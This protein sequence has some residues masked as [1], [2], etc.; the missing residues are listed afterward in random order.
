MNFNPK[1]DLGLS[2]VIWLSIIALLV[3]GLSPFFQE[4]AGIIGGALIFLFCTAIAGLIAWLWLATYYIFNENS[5]FIRGG[6][7]TKSV[8]FD[9]ISKVKLIRSWLA[10]AAT[11]S[12]R[13]EIHY[14]GYNYIHISPLDE[15]SFLKE[16]TKRCPHL[17]IEKSR[18]I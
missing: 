16:L 18:D 5:L 8:P 2:I 13:I 7:I 1:R 9:S 10:S 6:P 4:G 11:S 14:G 3:S 15:E 12:R 17:H